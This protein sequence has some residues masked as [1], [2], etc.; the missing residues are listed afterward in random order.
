MNQSFVPKDL[1]MNNDDRELGLKVYHLFVGEAGKLPGVPED[2]IVDAGPLA[3]AK[4][5]AAKPPATKTA[6][7]KAASSPAAPKKG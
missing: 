1:K 7:P 5:G 3:P 6:P 4:G 2:Q